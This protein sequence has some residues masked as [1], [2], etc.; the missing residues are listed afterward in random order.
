[1]SSPRVPA[2]TVPQQ[3]R[4]ATPGGTLPNAG[5][6]RARSTT[7]S[8]PVADGF[9]SPGSP[10]TSANGTTT[11]GALTQTQATAA[12][13]AVT[14]PQVQAGPPNPFAS[15]QTRSAGG[16]PRVSAETDA[17]ANAMAMAGSV[18]RDPPCD[19]NP[20][21][22]E[23]I[24]QRLSELGLFSGP[25]DGRYSTDMATAI[26]HFQADHRADITAVADA[27]GRDGFVDS[28]Y[29]NDRQ[30]TFLGGRIYPGDATHQALC[31]AWPHQVAGQL[32]DQE[33]AYSYFSSQVRARGLPFDET[34]TQ[35]LGLRGYQGGAVNDNAGSGE[36]TNPYNDT[37]VVLSPDHT[38]HEYRA[39]VDPGSRSADGSD[40]VS[41]AMQ[42]D[43]QATWR[44]ETV[45]HDSGHADR[46]GL[47]LQ[48]G[49]GITTPNGVT[50]QLTAVHAAGG[51]AF[52]AQGRVMLHSGDARDEVHGSSY[53]CQVVH[54]NWYP[55]FYADLERTAGT[56]GAVRYTLLDG[57][58]L[59]APQ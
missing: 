49:P 32:M 30:R 29:A 9:D 35:V 7:G 54:G 31:Q 36:A 51:D 27:G 59:T 11:A 44:M 23:R 25:V 22:V 58:H 4:I 40:R 6:A 12:T 45:G 55:S 52:A 26:Q 2:R 19:N 24:Q 47:Q 33:Q 28:E 53:G 50:D 39:T 37:M 34:Q 56:G 17:R 46:P 57:E 21:D 20:A 13:D 14:G 18:G 15:V 38:V 43:Q 8:T 41:F 3:L 48:L 10:R 42:A 5:V 16:L 1:M